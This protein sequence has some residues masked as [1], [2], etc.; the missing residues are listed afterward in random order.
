MPNRAFAAAMSADVH[1]VLR[2]QLLRED[3]QEDLCFALWTPSVGEERMTALIHTV[4]LPERGERQVHGNTS[5][6]PQ[7]LRRACEEAMRMGCGLALLH[8]HPDGRGWQG[9]SED[10]VEAE[11]RC[12]GPAGG[13]T[14]LPFVGLTLAGD[15]HWSGRVWTYQGGRVYQPQPCS[16]VRVV[17]KR[18]VP[19]FYDR[20]VP[21]PAFREQLRRTISVWG[22]ENH[23]QLARLRIGVVGLGSVGSM[24]AESLARM[25]MTDFVL[26]DFDVVEYVNLDRLVIA[27]EA[28][29]GRLK[30]EVA[31]ERIERVATA[32]GVRVRGVPY[33][34]VEPEGYR[35]ALDCDVLFSCVDRARPRHILNHLAYAH[36]ISV[37]DG[38]IQVRFKRE[39]FSGVDWQLQTAGPE[40][41]CLQCLGTYDPADVSTEE[42][43]MMDDP[44]YLAGLDTERVRRNE[45]VFPFA[46][47]LASLEVMQ[48]IALVTGIGGI[49]D[50][51]VQRYRYVPGIM[52]ADVERACDHS[53]EQPES[54]GEGDRHFSLMGRDLTA[55]RARSEHRLQRALRITA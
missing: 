52:Q 12:A 46:S 48:L 54:V 5:Y 1:R 30:V 40:R 23:A 47:N 22:E 38:G 41:A 31:Q 26:I 17:G 39:R 34:V 18:L 36:M 10:D 3:G 8:S 21:R 16:V 2:T 50:F 9:M 35:A 29:V 28:D 33:S 11:R 55:E 32:A 37:I 20:L 6:N 53:C 51:G 45:N 44:S 19:S 24:V 13:L 14:G 15:E 4:L 27:T 7:Y 42:A 49:D 43:G 25:G